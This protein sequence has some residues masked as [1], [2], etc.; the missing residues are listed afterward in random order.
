MRKWVGFVVV[1]MC[2]F[3]AP[4]YSDEVPPAPEEAV[5]EAPPPP[6]QVG[7]AANDSAQAA[8][9]ATA[10][11]VIAVGTVILG[12]T[13]LILVARHHGRSH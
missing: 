12:I 8:R 4:V 1:G 2:L 13:A 3:A 7:K 6:K 5:E 9:G 11:Y 10:K